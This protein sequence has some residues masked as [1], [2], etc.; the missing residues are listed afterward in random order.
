VLPWEVGRGAVV[1][2]SGVQVVPQ[3]IVRGGRRVRRREYPYVGMLLFREIVYE[4]MVCA[5]LLCL[6]SAQT[7]ARQRS[8]SGGQRVE[9]VNASSPARIVSFAVKAGSGL[10][11]P[12]RSV[13]TPRTSRQ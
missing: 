10:Q 12:V 5:R 13:G 3:R 8:E 2:R 11:L 6:M 4:D 9:A 1:A 7:G